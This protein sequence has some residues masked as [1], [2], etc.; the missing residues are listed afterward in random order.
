LGLRGG[1]EQVG[2]A[3]QI[4]EHRQCCGCLKIFGFLEAVFDEGH[5]APVVE[6]PP[7]GNR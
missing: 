2:V 3:V 1:Y 5:V 7:H 6:L 4:G